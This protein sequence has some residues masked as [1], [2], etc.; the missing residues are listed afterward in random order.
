MHIFEEKVKELLAVKGK[1][2]LEYPPDPKMG[3]L[4]FPCFILSKKLKKSP[5]EISKNIREQIS[6]PKYLRKI[7][8][9]V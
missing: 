8:K 4:A 2:V 5:G 6:V 1:I 7:Q 3:D 9:T